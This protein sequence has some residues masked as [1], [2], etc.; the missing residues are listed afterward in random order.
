MPYNAFAA[1]SAAR[2]LVA[3][4]L[5]TELGHAAEDAD[6]QAGNVYMAGA[7][8]RVDRAINRDLVA[9]A[10]KIEVVEPIAGDAVFGAGALDV[11]ASIGEGLR[12]AGGVIT[13]ASTVHGDLLL[14]GGRIELAPTAEVRGATWIAGSRVTV[15]GRAM[16]GLK[17]YGRNITIG[18]EVNGPLELSGR[19]IEVLS[20][21]RIHGDIE[22]SSGEQIRIDPAA[23]ISG[24][25]TRATNTIDISNPLA[26]IPIFQALRPL[27]FA[28]LLAAGLLLYGLFPRFTENASTLMREAPVRTLGLGTAVFFSV[29]PVALLLII[30]IIGI[31]VGILIGAFYAVALLAAYVVTCFFIGDTMARAMRRTPRTRWS[32][33]LLLML[34]LVILSLVTT[35][36]YIGRLLLLLACIAGLGAIGLQAF[37]RYSSRKETPAHVPLW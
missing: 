28:G 37:S 10:G 11:R 6:T 15:S 31:P 27:L 26:D 7:E 8:V 1:R 5:L 3:F 13:V 23:R 20:T 16:S 25:V 18:G 33:L 30:T 35:L 32:R 17:L 14:A 22:Y 2:C 29:P 12:A 4:T 19:H 21:A 34:G 9:A 36:P 24:K